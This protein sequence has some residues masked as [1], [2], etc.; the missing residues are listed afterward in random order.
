MNQR[1]GEQIKTLMFEVPEFDQLS[2]EEIDILAKH[3]F[4]KSVPAGTVLCKEGMSGDSLFYIVNGK[5]EIRKES[6]D[7]RQTVLARFNKGASVGEMSLVEESPRSATA[8]AV[9]DVELLILTRGSFETLLNENPYVGVKIL[10]NIAK[11][12]S[13]RLRFTSGRFADVFK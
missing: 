2:N 1:N 3:I 6:M 12:L 7:G 11:A 5:I 8:T 4:H 13:R 9:E 10:R